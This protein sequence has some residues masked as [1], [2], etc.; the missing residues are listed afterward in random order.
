MQL[1]RAPSIALASVGRCRC[2]GDIWWLATAVGVA[3]LAAL[4]VT[5]T[6]ARPTYDAMGFMVWGR[7]PC[8]GI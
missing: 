3:A 8:T 2:C 7:Q 6:K 5:I 1:E 4:F